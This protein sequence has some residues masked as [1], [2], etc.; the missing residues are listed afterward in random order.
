MH[1]CTSRLRSDFLHLLFG[2][3]YDLVHLVL[4]P[5]LGSLHV[6]DLFLQLLVFGLDLLVE[7]ALEL[8]VLL[9]DVF[10]N[11][12]LLFE[13]EGVSVGG[14]ALPAFLSLFPGVEQIAHLAGELLVFFP[15][16]QQ[17]R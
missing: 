11:A 4:I 9:L 13:V 10:F 16:G 17:Q 3:R 15:V 1:S 6:V 2:L 12:L 7:D 8:Q 14:Q 5:G